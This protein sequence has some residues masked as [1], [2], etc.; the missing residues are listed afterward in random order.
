MGIKR[1]EIVLQPGRRGTYEYTPGE[2]VNGKLVLKL[3]GSKTHKLS[4]LLVKVR[5]KAA[6]Y[7]TTGSGDD[8]QHYSA[9]Q[10]LLRLDLPLLEASSS[11]PVA[12]PSGQRH[13]P[14]TFSL[15]DPL[16]YSL[17]DSDGNVSFE[18][19]ARAISYSF[20]SSN[21]KARAE[22]RVLPHRDLS[23]E[24]QLA[25]PLT[26]QRKARSSLFSR[27][28]G[29]F[30]LHLSRQ[31]FVAGEVIDVWL[32]GPDR[33]FEVLA[34]ADEKVQLKAR[35]VFEAAGGDTEQTKR[36]PMVV[37]PGRSPSAWRHIQLT[38][39]DGE[40][41][42]DDSSGCT[43]IS[44]THYI[45]VRDVHLPVTLGTVPLPPK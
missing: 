20:W 14:F 15:P 13:F 17:R 4:A 16:A 40:V 33:A 45:K 1:T 37:R 29:P 42:M 30:Q 35:V 32:D 3:E 10:W 8:Q 22:F 21:G 39:P 19:K 25:R 28:P 34:A 24:P 26:V 6:T 44:I 38:V 23:R 2:T 36:V 9:K 12:L 11:H 7:W 18:C 43:I 41:T 5:G 31:G 27:D